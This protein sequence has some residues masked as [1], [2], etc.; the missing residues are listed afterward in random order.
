MKNERHY[1]PIRNLHRI[2]G[3]IG[4]ILNLLFALTACGSGDR[5][6]ESLSQGLT[7]PP[8][9]APLVVVGALECVPER[10]RDP[11]DGSVS[12][13]VDSLEKTIVSVDQDMRPYSVF[14]EVRVTYNSSIRISVP[15]EILGWRMPSLLGIGNKM[16]VE[17]RFSVH[18]NLDSDL[19]QEFTILTRDDGTIRCGDY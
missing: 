19:G 9:H 2:A 11:E 15:H 12:V 14:E 8:G 13:L 18:Y 17:R 5:T 7:P 16:V 3:R 1:S 6:S 10:L 4:L